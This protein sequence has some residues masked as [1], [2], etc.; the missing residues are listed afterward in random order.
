MPPRL[1]AISDLHVSHR[2]NAAALAAL[3]DH[4]D[5]EPVVAGDVVDSLS[6]LARAKRGTR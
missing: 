6:D 3:A 2:R 1:L 5:D 4:G